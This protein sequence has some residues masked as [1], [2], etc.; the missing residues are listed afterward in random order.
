MSKPIVAPSILASDF[1]RLE[2]EIAMVNAS[3][4]DWLH[5]DIMD[6]RFVPN[7]SFG[8]P[9]LK[10]M[11]SA[12]EKPLDVHIMIV[13][14][15][16]YFQA[17]KD[18]GASH[19]TFHVEATHHLDRAV[20]QV[21]ELGLKVGLALNPATPVASV[22]QVLPLLDIVCL[23]S[24]NPGFGGQKFIPYTLQKIQTLRKEIDRQNLETHIQIDGGINAQTGQSVVEAGANVLVA[25]SYVFGAS[26]PGHTISGLKE[27]G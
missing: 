19:I 23:M 1:G 27:L 5:C 24:V 17:C 6:G 11:A 3:E 25:G 10:A 22:F 7:I 18:H 8:F 15:E 12:S 2:E 14:P 20:H 21:K 16:K 13:E 4:A 26:N 9:V